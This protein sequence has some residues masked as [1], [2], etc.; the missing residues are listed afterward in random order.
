MS[1]YDL[2]E[3]SEKTN[4]VNMPTRAELLELGWEDRLLLHVENFNKTHAVVMLGGKAKIMRRPDS[5]DIINGRKCYEFL[6]PAEMNLIY[7]STT[8]QA[9]MKKDKYGEEYPYYLNH[10]AAWFQHPGSEVYRSGVVFMPEGNAPEGYFNTWQGL[11]V[12]P[13]TGCEYPALK[14]HIEGIIC[15]HN[16]ELID[17]FYDWVAY[18]FQLPHKPV[19]SALVLRGEKGSGK[20]I[21]G[22]FLRKIWGVH[23][24][25]VTQ[26]SQVTGNF[27]G[28]L[29]DVCFLYADEAFF[30]G[31]KKHEQTLKA[32]VTENVFVVERKGMDA[33]Q[34]RNCL[35]LFMTTN[36]SFAVPA[37]SDERRWGV[38]DVSDSM[39]GKTKYFD[40]LLKEANDTNV[41]A[42]FLCDML[43]RD[44]SGWKASKI[45]DSNGL[46]DQRLH[47]LDSMG[48]WLVDCVTEGTFDGTEITGRVHTS[49]MCASYLKW[50]EKHK[51][52]G[53]NIKSTNALGRYL[54][55]FFPK[56]SY[57]D[58]LIESQESAIARVEEVE[59]IYL[60]E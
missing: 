2:I 15:Q 40:A 13:K 34:A 54:H 19:K 11:S 32:L 41:M 18:G 50:C 42:S 28:H 8:I 60:G 58:Y 1:L 12:Y 10:F 14:A 36:N 48:Q 5:P 55:K 3:E 20:S 44:I 47:S 23:S 43:N 9:G 33:Q 49:V 56:N 37:S 7:K 51:V 57:K 26:S 30:S 25:Y 17:Y 46:K 52:S 16:Q 53:Y 22:H 24:L 29:V 31:D 38:Y 27:N 21:I 39:I 45:P 35:K 6:S 4:V 59:K